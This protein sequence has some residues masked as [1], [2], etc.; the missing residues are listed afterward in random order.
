[1]DGLNSPGREFLLQ[2]D[3]VRPTLVIRETVIARLSLVARADNPSADY[4]YF[5]LPALDVCLVR[6][7]HNGHFDPVCLKLLQ[8]TALHCIAIAVRPA[9]VT[10]NVDQRN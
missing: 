9:S 5:A 8:L 3:G 4:D 7:G 6:D 2:P 10:V 1:V